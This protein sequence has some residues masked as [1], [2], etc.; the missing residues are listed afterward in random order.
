MLHI[1]TRKTQIKATM[2]YHYKFT[3]M[4]IIKKKNLTITSVEKN[5]EKQRPSYIVGGNVKIW[6]FPKKLNINLLYDLAV[7]FLGISLQVMTL[8]IHTKTHRQYI[9][10]VVLFIMAPS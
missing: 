4:A 7:P 10:I 3:K 1:V 6:Q 9:Y 2:R 5:A 8:Y